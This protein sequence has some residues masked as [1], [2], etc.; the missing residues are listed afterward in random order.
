MDLFT[1]ETPGKKPP[2]THWST[3]NTFWLTE[4]RGSKDR[5]KL[6]NREKP[7]LQDAPKTAVTM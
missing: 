6:G 7:P 3:S 1:Y 2:N 4:V 5:F